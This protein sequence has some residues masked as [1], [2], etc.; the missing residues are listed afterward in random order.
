MNRTLCLFSAICLYIVCLGGCVPLVVGGAAVGTNAAGSNL[1]LGTQV[2]DVTI[3]SRA[4]KALSNIAGH[5][6]AISVSITSFNGI[7]LLLGE[8]PSQT[9]MDNITTAMTKIKGVNAVYNHLSIRTP[10][11]LGRSIKDSWITTKVKSNFVGQVNP[12]Q[13]KVITENRTVYLLALTN[14]AVGDRAATIAS[15]T[16]GVKKVVTCY[17]YITPKKPAAIKK[18]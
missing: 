14:K 15:K 2:N 8:V 12:M 13:F 3:K 1:S 18:K 7:I 11:G 6:D 5:N 16:S 10:L 4:I 17:V 9:I